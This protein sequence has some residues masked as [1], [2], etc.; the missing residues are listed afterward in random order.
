MD[1]ITW[2]DM[3]FWHQSSGIA[4]KRVARVKNNYSSSLD[5]RSAEWNFDAKFRLSGISFGLAARPVICYNLRERG[6]NDCAFRGR[7]ANW[8]DSKVRANGV[9]SIN[10]VCDYLSVLKLRYTD[11]LK[12]C[13]EIR[14][15]RLCKTSPS[16][17]VKLNFLK[18]ISTIFV[19]NV[20]EKCDAAVVLNK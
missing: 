16:Y 18:H 7:F 6:D 15:S 3:S 5:D 17:I 12:Y 1:C 2:R 20:T 13:K 19:K 14:G 4:D 9:K 10:D 11:D 8:V